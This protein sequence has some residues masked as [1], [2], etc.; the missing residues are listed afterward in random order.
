VIASKITGRHALQCSQHWYKVLDPTLVKGFWSPAEDA[1]LLQMKTDPLAEYSWKDI[2]KVI[3]T[4]SQKQCRERWTNTVNP[5]LKKGR[6]SEEEDDL[7]LNLWRKYGSRW[8]IIAD[9]LEGRTQTKI[10]DRFK[11][12]RRNNFSDIEAWEK[13]YGEHGSSSFKSS[14]TT[15]AKVKPPTTTSTST[16]RPQVFQLSTTRRWSPSEVFGP[17][18][19]NL[20]HLSVAPHTPQDLPDWLCMMENGTESEGSLD[21]FDAETMALAEVLDEG[22]LLW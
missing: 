8:S 2:S 17:G 4:R 15:P 3:E 13:K 21:E 9:H 16:N 10:R 7:L 22:S 20:E 5:K 14:T 1:K 18:A 6:F 12:M 11:T 19:A